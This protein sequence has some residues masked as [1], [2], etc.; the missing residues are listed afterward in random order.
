MKAR[1]VIVED[2]PLIADDLQS[3]LEEN[4]YEMVGMADNA[5][6]GIE[7]AKSTSPD[8]MLLDINIKGAIDGIMLAELLNKEFQIPFIFI[9]SYTDDQTIGKVKVLNPAGFIVK[10]FEDREVVTS[11]ELALHNVATET[12]EVNEVHDVT[13]ENLFVKH[14]SQLV[15]IRQEDIL[16]AEAYD[17]Y[18]YVNL[19]EKRYLLPSTL[20]AI[21]GRLD[22]ERFV[23]IHR[24]YLVN[25]GRIEVIGENYVSISGKELPVSKRHRQNLVQ[26][27][28]TL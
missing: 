6:D 17:N 20:K 28:K 24:S 4:G 12:D 18:C 5:N 2:E 25:L 16:W 3:I 19:P 23:R 7:L 21:E 27:I 1:V 8:L 13:Q 14:N 15:K 10:P 22:Q 11:V 9:S 26:R